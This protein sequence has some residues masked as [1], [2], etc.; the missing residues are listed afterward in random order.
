MGF[1]RLVSV[2]QDK[3][4]NYD[5]DV[6]MPLFTEIQK[7]TGA[8]PYTGKL[9]DEDPK[10]KDTAYRVIADHIRTLSFAIADGALPSNEGRGY[11]L[12]RILRR[13]VRYGRQMLGA[14]EGFFAALVPTVA[15]SLGDTFPE[16]RS[17]LGKVQAVIAE[18]EMAFTSTLSRG[19][20]EFS[21]YAATVKAQG[22]KTIDGKSAFF[23]YDTMGFPFDLTQLM[24]R[25]AGLE[26]DTEGF[27]EQIKQQ[28]ARSAAAAQAA[29]GG[30]SLTLGAEQTA[31]LGAQGHAYT[32]DSDKYSWELPAKP[33]KL[34]A[35]FTADGF[36]D[37]V[38]AVAGN[39]EETTV[40]LVLDVS[41]AL[42]RRRAVRA[43][44]RRLGSS[45]SA[46]LLTRRPLLRAET[47]GLADTCPV[48]PRPSLMR[49]GRPFTVWQVGRRAT[50]AHSFPATMLSSR[51]SEFNR[52]V[53]S[54]CT[55]ACCDVARWPWVRS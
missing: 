5:T 32:D 3:R 42:L 13:A 14:Q 18:E 4:S 28:R 8:P 16:L 44:R 34:Q 2:L 55:Q 31:A 39:A 6:F 23:L 26:V 54:C 9:G 36:V 7:L 52:M 29:K 43:T 47:C 21:S 17:Q 24:A 37:R 53:A 38:Q 25:E 50:W 15:A 1:E 45:V 22:V 46:W 33:S 19:I 49:R 35:I 10:L 27:N 11:V 41:A 40:G 12:R 48:R 20:K 30:G 51:C